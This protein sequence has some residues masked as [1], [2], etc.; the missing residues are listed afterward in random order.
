MKPKFIINVNSLGELKR[1]VGEAPAITQEIIAYFTTHCTS[2]Y[3]H[4]PTQNLIL[5]IGF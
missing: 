1:M 4:D 2:Q 3:Y 5:R